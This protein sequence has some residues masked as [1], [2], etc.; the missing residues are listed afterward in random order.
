[1]LANSKA[2]G[3]SFC[4]T[5]KDLLIGTQLKYSSSNLGDSH[6]SLKFFS[7]LNQ[8]RKEEVPP[9]EL[10]INNIAKL[11]KILN[12][13]PIVELETVN[14]CNAKCQFC[15]YRKQVI[16]KA[17]MDE[18][19]FENIACQI[20][21]LGTGQLCLVPMLGDPLLDDNISSHALALRRLCNLDTIRFVT[22]G[23][24]FYRHSD[25]QLIQLFTVL[26]SLEGWE[27]DIG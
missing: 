3:N 10:I 26:D 2:I 11:S 22:N 4:T 19:L 9:S 15:I 23:L 8:L 21:E 27:F 20:S 6:L 7:L 25:E 17:V 13:P 12:R 14:I 24:G 18:K 1:M 16:K 5:G